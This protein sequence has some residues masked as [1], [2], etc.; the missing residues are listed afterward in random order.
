MVERRVSGG[1]PPSLQ[2]GEALKERRCKALSMT[3]PPLKI[4]TLHASDESAMNPRLIE[5]QVLS[6]ISELL[7]EPYYEGLS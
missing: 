1:T 7:E 6:E 3:A 2:G 4:S 5:P